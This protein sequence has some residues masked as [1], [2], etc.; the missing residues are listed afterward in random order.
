M[1]ISRAIIYTASVYMS[2]NTKFQLLIRA[3]AQFFV[4]VFF[5]IC[6]VTQTKL[7]ISGAQVHSFTFNI[8]SLHGGDESHSSEV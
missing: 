1:V 2:Y 8:F 5:L 7:N 3:D 6:K 4:F